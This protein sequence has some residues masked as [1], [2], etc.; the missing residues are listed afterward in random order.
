MVEHVNEQVD[1]N[2][3]VAMMPTNIPVARTEREN[4]SERHNMRLYKDDFN[5]LVYW[6]DR[7]GMDRTEFLITAMYHYIKWRNQDYEL[8]PMEVQRLNQMVDAIQNLVVNQSNL[9]N[10][11]IN[12]F[13]AMLGIIRGD[14]YLVEKD[15]GTL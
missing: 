3:D 1:A 14:N 6:A 9:E 2:M 13:D 7:F 5:M 12:G 4:K 10:T 8:P 11:V 15:E